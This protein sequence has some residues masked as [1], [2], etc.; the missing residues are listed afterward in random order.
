MHILY[1]HPPLNSSGMGD[2][3]KVSFALGHNGPVSVEC[4]LYNEAL[5]FIGCLVLSS[6]VIVQRLDEYQQTFCH[7]NCHVLTT[8]IKELAKT[9]EEI[10]AYL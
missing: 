6:N 2:V 3:Q 7:E 4:P 1:R 9:K 8:K 5:A 10:S